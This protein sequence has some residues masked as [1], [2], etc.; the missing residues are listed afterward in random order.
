MM[1]VASSMAAIPSSVVTFFFHSRE[2]GNAV[3]LSCPGALVKNSE[4][5]TSRS[6]S[7]MY[8]I[9][10]R[11]SALIAENIVVDAPMPKAIARTAIAVNPGVFTSIRLAYL[12]SRNIRPRFNVYM[13]EILANHCSLGRHPI[14]HDATVEE[15]D[16]AI[17]MFRKTSVM[18]NHADRRAAI[19]QFL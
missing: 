5:A 3:P 18:R 9:G 11:R 6:W 13:A 7:W 1:N 19:V 10:R 8:G 2:S 15:M 16:C 17:G 14:F 4:T 12:R